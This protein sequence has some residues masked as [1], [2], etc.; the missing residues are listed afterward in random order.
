MICLAVKFHTSTP[1]VFGS[2]LGSSRQSLSSLL[3]LASLRLL[4]LTVLP[5]LLPLPLMLLLPSFC[6]FG[7]GNL[8]LPGAAVRS[9]SVAAAVHADLLTPALRMALPLAGAA[10]VNVLGSR[11]AAAQLFLLLR[12]RP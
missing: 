11:K 3:L 4:F 6:C 10:V 2:S 7:C 1:A 9:G 5:L 8:V 12:T